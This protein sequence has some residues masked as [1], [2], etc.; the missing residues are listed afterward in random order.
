[1]GVVTVLNNEEREEAARVDEGAPHASS[2]AYA[3]ARCAYLSVD[4]STTSA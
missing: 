1:L 4:T 2:S 3:A